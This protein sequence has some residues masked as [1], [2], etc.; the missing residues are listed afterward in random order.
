[1]KSGKAISVSFYGLETIDSFNHVPDRVIVYQE[2]D[3]K[4]EPENLEDIGSLS[5]DDEPILDEIGTPMKPAQSFFD[6]NNVDGAFT[7][8]TVDQYTSAFTAEVMKYIRFH[9]TE[10]RFYLHQNVA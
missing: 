9:K 10:H 4:D 7:L 3:E 5:Q 6:Y 8:S 2:V 1:M